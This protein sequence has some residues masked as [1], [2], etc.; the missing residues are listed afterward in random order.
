MGLVFV[1]AGLLLMSGVSASDDWTGLLA[2]LCF[3]GVGIGMV[4]P[5]LAT[6]AVGVV[7][8]ARAGMASG[9]NATF[10]Q[11]GIAR[12]I[13]AW[14]AIFQSAVDGQADEFARAV[15]GRMPA[16]QEGSFSDS[17]PSACTGSSGPTPS[18]PVAR[19]SSS[20]STG[21]FCAQA[22]SPSWVP[23]CAWC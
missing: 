2:G 8:A 10:R 4:N 15:G 22:F 16:G 19:P 20:G 14:G 6:A 21:S 12:G 7:K 3:T 1:A 18:K 13:A 17:S 11:V 5:P 23:S 9:I